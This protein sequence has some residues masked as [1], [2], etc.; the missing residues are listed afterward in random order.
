MAWSAVQNFA[1]PEA[2]A[3]AVQGAAFEIFPTARG[4][5]QCEMTKVRFDRV[6]MSRF[7]LTLPQVVTVAARPDRRFFTFPTE[8]KSPTLIHGGIEALPGDII[9]NS[10]D[11]THRRFGR[12]L[13][14]GSMSFPASELKAIQL[15]VLGREL[16]EK[17]QK[18][19]VRPDAALMS[20]LLKLHKAIEQ[21][22]HDAPEILEIPEVERAMEE[23]LTHLMIRCLADSA[24]LPITT[25]GHRHDAIMSRFEKFL[26]ANPD[27]PLYLTEICGAI[28]VA[29]RTLRGA[30]E[31]HI[32]MGP[33]RYL[34]LRR[35]HLARRALQHA[36]PSKSTVTRIATDHGFWEL[37]RFSVA[38]R[39]LFGEA[40]S[41]TLRR[42]AER[43]EIDL[44]RP[45]SIPSPK[46]RSDQTSRSG[47]SSA[48]FGSGAPARRNRIA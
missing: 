1:D 10:H 24:G 46:C 48:N 4:P 13:R 34:T 28:G 16:P 42:P 14:Y 32:G 7:H 18:I 11:V 6:W 3:A 41:E 25:R 31:E 22:A 43:L 23:Q 12:D 27:R 35:M 33:I 15:A 20:R 5:Y 45:S 21:L 40:P 30:C 47:L 17:Q 37:G 39:T 8:P 38:Y 44:G 36:D 2:C 19:V 9:I 29:E 26:E